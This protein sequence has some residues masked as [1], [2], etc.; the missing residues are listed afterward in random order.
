[1]LKQ[2][3]QLLPTHP[4][5]FIYPQL[6]DWVFQAA[7]TNNVRA[8]FENDFPRTDG[9]DTSDRPRTAA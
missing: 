3:V 5:F 2:A 6:I 7:Q 8:C 1:M 4:L 9:V